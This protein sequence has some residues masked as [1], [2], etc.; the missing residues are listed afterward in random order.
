MKK[1]SL[2]VFLCLMM[3]FVAMG[4]DKLAPSTR[5]FLS[6]RNGNLKSNEAIDL[7][8]LFQGRKLRQQLKL[9]NGKAYAPYAIAQCGDD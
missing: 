7:S 4:Q 5:L 9:R 3:C 8:K 6:M 1:L 2:S